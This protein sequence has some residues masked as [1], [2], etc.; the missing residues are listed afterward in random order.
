MWRR[1]VAVSVWIGAPLPAVPGET[2]AELTDRL[3][4][5]LRELVDEVIAAYPDSPGAGDEWWLPA[6]VGGAAP[7]PEQAA[8]DEHRSIR[9]HTTLPGEGPAGEPSP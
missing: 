1:K 5:R 2:A 8:V 7:T 4:V 3:A 6:H 9:G